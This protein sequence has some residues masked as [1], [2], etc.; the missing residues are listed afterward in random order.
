MTPIPNLKLKNNAMY[1]TKI[2]V[3]SEMFNKTPKACMQVKNYK[4]I[5][6]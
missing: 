2:K 5:K 4:I 3:E 6:S 1:F